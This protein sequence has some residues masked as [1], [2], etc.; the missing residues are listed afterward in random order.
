MAEKL[1]YE[2]AK[3]QFEKEGYELLSGKYRGA[4]DKLRY[5]CPEGHEHS[6]TWGNWKHGYRCPY[7]ARNGKP[8]IEFIQSEFEKEGYILLTKQYKNNSQKLEYICSNS[9]K[10]RIG[11]REWCCG[12]RCVY[13][14]GNSKL[15]IEFIEAEFEKENYILLTTEYKNC[16]QKLECVCPKGH[17]YSISWDNWNHGARCSTCFYINNSGSDHYNWKGGISCEPYWPF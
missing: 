2:F 14:A 1:T 9:H 16:S 10:H 13:C 8:T 7:C 4:H 5:R 12:Q 15:T 3:E 11:W 17:R 6:I